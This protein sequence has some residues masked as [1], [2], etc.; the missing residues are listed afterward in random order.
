MTVRRRLAGAI[1]AATL[2]GAT[3]LAIPASANAAGH[4]IGTDGAE[5]RCNASPY[6]L[7][8]Y[9]S[10]FSSAYWGTS[11]ND[12][13][14]G[15]NHF[16][17]GTGSGAGQVVR[18]NAARMHCDYYVPNQCFSYYNTN[19]GGNYDWEYWHDIGTLYFTW[20]DEASVKIT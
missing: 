13:N 3:A 6:L 18:N 8:L 5:A 15:D 17:S 20:N 19:Y 1:I 11:G 16:F 10:T 9:Y 2:G 7:C 14:L 12:T 4:Y